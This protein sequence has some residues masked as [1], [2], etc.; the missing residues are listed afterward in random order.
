MSWFKWAISLVFLSSCYLPSL[1]VPEREEPNLAYNFPSPRP[2]WSQFRVTGY[3]PTYRLS[4]IEPSRLP[5]LTDLVFFAG[6][7]NADGSLNINKS[8]HS[9]WQQVKRWGQEYHLRIHLGVKDLGDLPYEQSLAKITASPNLRQR[10][11]QSLTTQALEHG[12]AGVDIDWEYPRGE[13]LGYFVAFL[14]DLRAAFDP[15]GLEL[16]IAVSPYA[17]VLSESYQYVDQVH[18]MSYDD[19]GIH[20]SYEKTVQHL[21]IILKQVPPHRVLLGLPFYG[22]LNSTSGMGQ[23]MSYRD[24][25]KT[26]GPRPDDDHAGGFYYNGPQTIAQKTRLAR[27]SGLLGVMVWELGQDAPGEASLL[28]AITQSLY[29]Y[30]P[31]VALRQR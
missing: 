28:Q 29:E 13:S 14:K 2:D 9:Q 1:L 4:A 7:P 10:F 25:V 31:L 15:Y 26:F 20:S 23:A 12:F 5:Y 11:V 21:K 22:R 19:K 27:R 3:L 17:P 24:I 6:T 30:T 8:Q 18:L 16:S